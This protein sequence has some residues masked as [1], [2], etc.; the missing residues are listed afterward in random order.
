MILD[1]DELPAS[2]VFECHRILRLIRNSFE[3]NATLH[4]G[5]FAEGVVR[6]FEVMNALRGFEIVALYALFENAV[7][8]RLGELVCVRAPA[9]EL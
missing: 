1:Q 3:P 2:I 9:P 8:I 4:I 6:G 7:D 5:L